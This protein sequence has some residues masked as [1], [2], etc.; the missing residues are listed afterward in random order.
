MFWKKDTD[1]V[2]TDTFPF[3]PSP[4]SLGYIYYSISKEMFLIRKY[5]KAESSLPCS[6]VHSS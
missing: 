4:Y 6:C 5:A 3:P 2:G 1:T